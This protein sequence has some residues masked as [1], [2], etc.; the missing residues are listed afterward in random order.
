MLLNEEGNLM[1]FCDGL[2]ELLVSFGLIR[3][4]RPY[5]WPRTEALR[6]ERTIWR[7]PLLASREALKIALGVR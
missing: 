5:L 1:Y 4:D 3:P 2:R 6:A 7:P